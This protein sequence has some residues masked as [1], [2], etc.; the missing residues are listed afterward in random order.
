MYL[1]KMKLTCPVIH[2]QG[3]NK[4]DKTSSASEK[5]EGTVG[6]V[7][8]FLRTGTRLGVCGSSQLLREMILFTVEE[9]EVNLKLEPDSA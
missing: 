3:V 1:R 7:G 2:K 6:W 8:N 4:T 5:N 9:P